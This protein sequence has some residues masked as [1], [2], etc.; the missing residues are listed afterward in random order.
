MTTPL[1]PIRRR[2]PRKVVS[3]EK[4]AAELLDELREAELTIRELSERRLQI[5]LEASEIGLTTTKIG[6]S[7]GA[8]QT[9][10]SKWVR[11]AHVRRT[12]AASGAAVSAAAVI[13]AV[14]SAVSENP[15]KE[16]EEVSHR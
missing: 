9:A 5:M 7:I 14:A 4:R 11:I 10:V 15:T 1:P 8:S 12:I 6:E 3:D 13:A 2:K 16:P